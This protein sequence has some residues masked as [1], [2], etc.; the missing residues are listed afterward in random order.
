MQDVVKEYGPALLTII[1]ILSLATLL[2]WL[3]QGDE[4]GI[5]GAHFEQLVDNFFTNAKDYAG[6]E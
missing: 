3:F 4:G 2:A 1:A 5:I 6:L